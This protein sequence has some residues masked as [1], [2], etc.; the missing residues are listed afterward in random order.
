MLLANLLFGLGNLFC[1]FAVEKWMMIAGRLLAGLGGGALNAVA[2]IMISDY[3]PLRQRGLW[4]GMGNLCWGLGNGLGGVFGGYCN[5]V[6]G[7]DMAFLAQTPLTMF[8]IALVYFDVDKNPP[9]AQ[10]ESHSSKSSIRRVDFL[11]SFLL[12]ATLVVFLLGINTGPI[13][14]WN[15]P[16]VITSFVIS[17][18]LFCLFVYVE[19][20]VATEPII[21]IRLI[22]DRTV[23]CGCLANWLFS[24]IVYALLYYIPIYFRVRGK[25]STDAGAALVP[26]SIFNALGSF[27]AGMMISK[28][29]NYRFFKFT[30]PVVMLAATILISLFN[31]TTATW[32]P[33]LCMGLVGVSFGGMIM[34]T[35][36]ALFSAVET[37]DQAVVTSL[38]YTFRSTGAVMGVALASAIFQHLLRTSLWAQLGNRENGAEIIGKLLHSLNEID[39]LPALDQSLAR[40]GY[41]HALTAIF[42]GTVVLAVLGLISASLI[43]ELKLYGTLT[44]DDAN[45]PETA[46][47]AH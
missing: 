39:R 24:V 40:Q 23:A 47:M 36:L 38:S 37:A 31:L 45:D 42:I 19:E 25:S 7:W 44:R 8:C 4:Q 12:V 14:T 9:N 41:M 34:V 29:G 18:P 20:R 16:L 3:I 33:L 5:D 6:W 32:L 11:G 15:H 1:G 17:A 27:G 30:C 22:F 26:F 10:Y 13:A 28:M 43:R 46:T 35:L 2:T 21:P